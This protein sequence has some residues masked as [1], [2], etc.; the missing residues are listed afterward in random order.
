MVDQQ[1]A[2]LFAFMA[3]LQSHFEGR[4]GDAGEHL[5][6]VRTGVGP[7]RGLVAV[8]LIFQ[9]DGKAAWYFHVAEID[10]TL[11]QGALTDFVQRLAA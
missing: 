10:F 9:G 7:G 6:H 11:W 5:R 4:A 1:L 3:I 2:A 8:I